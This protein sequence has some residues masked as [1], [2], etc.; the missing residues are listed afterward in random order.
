MQPPEISLLQPLKPATL[1]LYKQKP[2]PYS[3]YNSQTSYI[4]TKLY[5]QTHSNPQTLI[6]PKLQIYFHGTQTTKKEPRNQCASSFYR[7]FFDGRG[8]FYI[9]KRRNRNL[10][11]L[12]L[13]RWSRR[14]GFYLHG[15]TVISCRWF[16]R[17]D[18]SRSRWLLF[19]ISMLTPRR[20]R[21]AFLWCEA[22]RW[23]T[24]LRRFGW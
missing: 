15:R 17:E 21:T 5:T 24:D 20:K 6:P 3:S 18:G 14:G 7:L 13:S 22:S 16:S 23:I 12:W 8:W 2:L 4:H 11:G 19:G 1:T 9:Y 10:H